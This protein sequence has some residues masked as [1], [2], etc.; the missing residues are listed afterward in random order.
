MAAG[1]PV[2]RWLAFLL[3]LAGSL[4]P[5]P[6]TPSLKNPI[7]KQEDVTAIS[8]E[9]PVARMSDSFAEQMRATLACLRS[10]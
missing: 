1:L 8:I 5:L 7:L 6:A 3:A 10:A 9:Q 2:E 4:S